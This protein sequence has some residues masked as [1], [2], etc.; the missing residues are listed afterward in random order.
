MTAYELLD[1][2]G[3]GCPGEIARA[4]TKNYIKLKS[5]FK[6]NNSVIRKILNDRG[7]IYRQIGMDVLNYELVEKIVEKAN[8]EIAFAAFVDMAVTNKA[9]NNLDAVI[10]NFDI[11]VQVI[12][13]N[14]NRLVPSS[15]GIYDFT[16]FND[17]LISFIKNELI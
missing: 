10:E 11:S 12:L 2:G 4:M 1:N 9:T 8:G 5:P 16:S 14:Y 3:P 7:D 6:S 13:D 17:R 15:K